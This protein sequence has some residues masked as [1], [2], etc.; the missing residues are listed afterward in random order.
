MPR[1]MELQTQ[2]DIEKIV[3]GLPLHPGGEEVQ[4][5]PS[6]QALIKGINK[7]LPAVEIDRQNE[8]YSS[9]EAMELMVKMGVKRNKRSKKENLDK[10][11]AAIILQRYLGNV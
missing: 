2:Y 6:I 7:K 10:M 1:L 5:E 3:I 4:L 11:A 9:A 8:S